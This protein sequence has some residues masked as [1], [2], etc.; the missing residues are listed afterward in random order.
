[1][2]F[3]AG[4]IWSCGPAFDLRGGIRRGSRYQNRVVLDGVECFELHQPSGLP[5]LQMQI[6]QRTRRGGRVRSQGVG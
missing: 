2:A 5:V 3:R 6:D 4:W 1:M